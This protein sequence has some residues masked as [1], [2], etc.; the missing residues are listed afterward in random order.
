M[1]YPQIY[2]ILKVARN[3]SQVGEP[4]LKSFSLRILSL[5]D[6]ISDKAQKGIDGLPNEV[7]DSIRAAFEIYMAIGPT[8]RND[9]GFP[10]RAKVPK[11]QQQ[12]IALRCMYGFRGPV[13]RAIINTFYEMVSIYIRAFARISNLRAGTKTH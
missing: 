2:D 6:Q 12:W 7:Q 8:L 3:P 5:A 4:T 9:P 10:L 13:A 1:P 11:R